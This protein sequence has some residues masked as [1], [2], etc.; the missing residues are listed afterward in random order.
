MTQTSVL[1]IANRNPA[2]ICGRA[3]GKVISLINPSFLTPKE[4]ATQIVRRSTEATTIWVFRQTGKNAAQD[5][6]NTFADSL[7]PAQTT[8]SG[9]SAT[10]GNARSALNT[11]VS[12]QAHTGMRP[13]N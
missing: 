11:G 4:R 9:T 1:E 13:V 12:S 2:R 3:A 10:G 6:M 5:V 7:K 8:T